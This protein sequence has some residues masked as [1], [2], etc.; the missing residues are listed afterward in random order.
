MFKLCSSFLIKKNFIVFCQYTAKRVRRY[1]L[2]TPKSKFVKII[3]FF[4]IKC[5]VY[6]T[7]FMFFQKAFDFFYAI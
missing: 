7:F 5:E 3:N 1:V 4:L 2:T 6:Y